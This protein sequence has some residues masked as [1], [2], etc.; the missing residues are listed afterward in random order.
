[1]NRT[2][3][4]RAGRFA[5]TA[6]GT[7]AA[8]LALTACGGAGAQ[9]ESNAGAEASVDPDGIIEAGISYALSG[10]FDPMVASGAVTVAA[11]W[12]IFEG[13]VDLNPVTKEPEATLAADLPKQID[14]THY[15]IDLREGA[16]FH[17]G[18]PVTAEDVVFSYERVLDP[19]SGSLFT[20]FVDFIDTVTAVDEDTVEI[21]TDFPFSLLNERLGVVKIV[22]RALVEQDAEAFGAQPVGSG[23]YKLVSATPDD[24]I[25]FERHE[26]YDGPHPA[27][28]AGMNWNLLSDAAARTTALTSGT[29]Q[30]M[31]DV[32]YIDV[33]ALGESA[34][35]ESVQSFGLLFMMFNTK[36]KP[37]D[38]VRVRQAL[39]YALD[40]DKIIETG[41]LG[42]AEAATSFLPKTHPNYH[43]ASTVY[44]YDPE[45]AKALLAEAGVTDLDLTILMTDTG[46][47]KELA[48]LVK[49]SLDGVGIK[50]TLDI[51]QSAAQYGKTDAG[52]YQVMIAPGDPSVFGNDA[53]L[54]MQWWYGDNVWPQ[55]RYYW[56]DSAE[57]ATLQGLLKEAVQQTGDEQQQTWNES[58]DLLSEEVP[59]YPLFHR[60]LPTAWDADGLVGF[61]P[62]STTGLSFLDVGVAAK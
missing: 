7:L 2:T 23:P 60:K 40:M 56:D 52:D 42:N 53:D 21:A 11:N 16:T 38:D 51:A 29:I 14:D 15:E 28:A 27:L 30:A 36:V 35:V 18:T 49:E 33:N 62:V 50:T 8:A 4:R 13:L 47:V 61:E 59:L 46:W 34:T 39:F 48:P 10:S 20:P 12:H 44:T 55:T 25:V 45:K 9:P 26:E 3:Q 43:E 37:F 54:L 41:L 58:F 17:D 5:A 19:A 6:A 24:A 31:E 57:F 1:M 22:P 32:P